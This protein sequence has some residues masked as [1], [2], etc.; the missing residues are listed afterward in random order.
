MKNWLLL[1]T[2]VIF[3]AGLHA[4]KSQGR[5]LALKDAV[6]QTWIKHQHELPQYQVSIPG[7]KQSLLP[8]QTNRQ[9]KNGPLSGAG[10]FQVNDS[11][12]EFKWDTVGS[13]WQTKASSRTLFTYDNQGRKTGELLSKR[14]SAGRWRNVNRSATVYN[15]S[16]DVIINR[17]DDWD[18]IS[19]AWVPYERDSSTFN[20]HHQALVIKWYFYN[21]IHQTW[22][23]GAYANINNTGFE[24][25]HYSLD[26]NPLTYAISGG[27]RLLS[28]PDAFN[29]PVE[30]IFKIYN[31]VTKTWDN[32]LKIVYVYVRDTLPSTW[33]TSA[34]VGS[35]W[36]NSFRITFTYVGTTALEAQVLDESWDIPTST[37]KGS[38]RTTNTYQ[39]NLI[40]VELVENWDLI[41]SAWVGET[42]TT[43]TYQ[44]NLVSGELFE[45]WDDVA[46]VWVNSA[47]NTY[48]YLN[49]HLSVELQETWDITLTVPAWVNASRTNISYFADYKTQ[50]IL[51]QEWTTAWV[52]VSR[53]LFNSAGLPVEFWYKYFTYGARSLF[54]YNQNN[55]ILNNIT[56]NWNAHTNGWRNH[57]KDV[58]YYSLMTDVTSPKPDA[59][60]CEFQ[61]PYLPGTLIQCSMLKAGQT[62]ELSLYAMTGN[63]VHR[64]LL[65]GGAPFSINTFQPEG[66]Y[67]MTIKSNSARVIS[68]KI[69]M[70]NR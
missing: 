44:N 61:N 67:L 33:T 21:R 54:E 40:T 56:Q 8:L 13:V 49:S 1:A 55:L 15:T 70:L 34:W 11:I 53:A 41:T 59:L 23:M 29:Q 48:T 52:D 10:T 22:F 25:D 65:S 47:R 18:T 19:S 38:T 37:W 27:S 6:Q 60:A 2:L 35:A 9:L 36:V 5:R 68:Q 16:G 57:L 45:T 39:N 26:W 63:R 28:T 3:S 20:T 30:E 12:Y 69:I 64:Q 24:L 58:Y 32:S 7:I 43:Y 17:Y 46:K 42:R 50:E 51:S 4:Q 31:T 62:Y 14:N 66:V